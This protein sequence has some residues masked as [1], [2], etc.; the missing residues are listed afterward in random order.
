MQIRW[1]NV[2]A[3]VQRCKTN[4]LLTIPI[5]SIDE[6]YCTEVDPGCS[7]SGGGLEK[8]PSKLKTFFQSRNYIKYFLNICALF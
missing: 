4:K 6:F 8:N 3:K 2:N 1:E 7:F 5:C